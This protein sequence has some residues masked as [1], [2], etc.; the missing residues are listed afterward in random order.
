MGETEYKQSMS[1][2]NTIAPFAGSQIYQALIPLDVVRYGSLALYSISD[3][4]L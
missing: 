2:Q 3:D 1:L 4:I